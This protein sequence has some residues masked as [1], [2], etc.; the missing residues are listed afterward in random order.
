MAERLLF[1]HFNQDMVTCT[2]DARHL[3]H[4]VIEVTH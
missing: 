4:A 2:A 1:R 3:T